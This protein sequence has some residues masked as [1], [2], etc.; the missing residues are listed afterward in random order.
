MSRIDEILDQVQQGKIPPDEGAKRI[1]ERYWK[2]RWRNT[3][4]GISFGLYLI[5]Q[6]L[7]VLGYQLGWF[8]SA[9]NAWNIIWPVVLGVIGIHM[10]VSRA[11][12]GSFSL[13]GTLLLAIGAA[14]MVVNAQIITFS[15][16]W[17]WF[18]PIC[19]IV[20][21][22]DLLYN[23]LTGKMKSEFIYYED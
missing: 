16:W 4:C 13:L 22:L 23:A 18:W 9:G 21:G 10:L 5:L 2:M 3:A 11:R 12:R 17:T 1:K 7:A 14:R 20:A 19:L 6:G 15:E 8:P